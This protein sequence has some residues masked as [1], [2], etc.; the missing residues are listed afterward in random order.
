MEKNEK[1]GTVRMK[2]F[3]ALKRINEEYSMT[4]IIGGGILKRFQTIVDKNIKNKDIQNEAE[5]ETKENDNSLFGKEILEELGIKQE[6]SG[7][8]IQ[9][10]TE[11]ILR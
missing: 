4:T 9:E 6:K 7:E 2:P 1:V 3:Y 10:E 5:T 8:Y 11:E